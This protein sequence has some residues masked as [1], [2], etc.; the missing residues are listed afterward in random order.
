MYAHTNAAGCDETL[1]GNGEDYRGCQS[2]TNLGYTCQNW[3]DQRS[4]AHSLKLDE[5]GLGNHNHCRNPDDEITI[6][7]YTTDPNKEWDYCGP[8]SMYA[9]MFVYVCM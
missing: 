8:I 3:V 5:K 1:K 7:C 9:C 2:V 6:W 4:H